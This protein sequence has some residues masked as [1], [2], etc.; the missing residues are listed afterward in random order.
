MS[1]KKTEERVPRITGAE[2][3]VSD[4]EAKRL[5]EDGLV[6]FGWEEWVSYKDNYQKRIVD[7]ARIN[8]DRIIS[9]DQELYLGPISPDDYA[10]WLIKMRIYDKRKE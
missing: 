3:I 5:A 4:V 7:K 9:Y 2:N 8:P 10:E 1:N 6:N